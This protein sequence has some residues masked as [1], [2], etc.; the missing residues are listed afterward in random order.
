MHDLPQPETCS[1]C[2]LL[3]YKF[4]LLV[5]TKTSYATGVSSAARRYTGIEIAHVLEGEVRSKV[6]DDPENITPRVSCSWR[7]RIDF[8]Q[9]RSMRAQPSLRD[10]W[11]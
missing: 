6:G 4:S 11:L 5:L 8:M 3:L 10:S 9:F 2:F 7:L 1:F